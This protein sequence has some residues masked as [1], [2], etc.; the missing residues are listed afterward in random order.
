MTKIHPATGNQQRPVAS[1][2]LGIFLG[3]LVGGLGLY[4]LNTRQGQKLSQELI[5]TLDHKPESP[6]ASSAFNLPEA[7]TKLSQVVSSSPTLEAKSEDVFESTP[8]T[9]GEAKTMLE[10]LTEQLKKIT[11]NSQSATD[12][13]DKAEDSKRFFNKSGKRLS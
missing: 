11:G 6:S 1:Y 7:F 4:L 10:K 5:N 9:I 2:G 8:I 13:L 3:G 12:N